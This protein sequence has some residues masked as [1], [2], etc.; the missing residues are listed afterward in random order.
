[1]SANAKFQVQANDLNITIGLCHLAYIPRLFY[2][3][4]ND[5]LFVLVIKIVYDLLMTGGTSHV[6]HFIEMLDS[7]Y[8][9]ETVV[10]EPDEYCFF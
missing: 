4:H 8:K 10:S 7:R 5:K 2:L 9:F 6:E 3:T 1:M